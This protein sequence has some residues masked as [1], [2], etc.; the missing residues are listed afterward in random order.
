MSLIVQY[1]RWLNFG[2][3]RSSEKRYFLQRD[4]ESALTNATR[5]NLNL[6]YVVMADIDFYV[7]TAEMPNF[8]PLTRVP[9]LY[10]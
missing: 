9:S 8:Y 5:K 3:G 6:P 10:K 2:F 7:A 1:Q 4:R